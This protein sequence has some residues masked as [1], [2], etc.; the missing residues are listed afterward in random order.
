M[1]TQHVLEVD[2]EEI[3][4]KNDWMKDSYYHL[5]LGAMF[6]ISHGS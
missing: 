4:F 5:E 1:W 3:E 6:W 2:I